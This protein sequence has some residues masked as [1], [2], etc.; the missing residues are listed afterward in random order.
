MGRTNKSVS[1][2]DEDELDVELLNH[3]E[4][5]NRLTGKK[6]N[7]SKY[8]KR[9][10]D[11]DIKR[12]AAGNKRGLPSIEDEPIVSKKKDAYTLELMQGYL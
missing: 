8:V 10:I 3:A 9:L 2:N 12:E 11:E 1:F 7:F 4:R 5:P 6:R